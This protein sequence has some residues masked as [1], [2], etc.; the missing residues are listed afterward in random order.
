MAE[1]VTAAETGGGPKHDFWVVPYADMLTLLFAL[2]VVLYSIGEVRLKKLAELRRSFAFALGSEQSPTG[3]SGQFD[4]GSNSAG[5]LIEGLELINAQSGPMRQLLLETLPKQFE[6]VFGRSLEVVVT[7][8]TVAFTAPLD[9][10]WERGE[11]TPREDAQ[12][13]LFDLFEGIGRDDGTPLASEAEIRI[14]APDSIVGRDANGRSVRTEEL[15]T[16]RLTRLRSLLRLV[17][18][19]Q[20]NDISTKFWPTAPST[21]DWETEAKITFAFSTP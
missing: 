12:I 11:V 7:D 14:E 5:D 6:E 10:L 18:Q 20:S 1:H 8:D 4:L 3:E 19:A 15:C 17:P 9:A 2:F 13:W 16:K 21:G